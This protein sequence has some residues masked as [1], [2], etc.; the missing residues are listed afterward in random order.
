MQLLFICNIEVVVLAFSHNKIVGIVILISPLHERDLVVVASIWA[1]VTLP[2]PS[3]DFWNETCYLTWLYFY[4]V[5][6]PFKSNST[7]LSGI[8]C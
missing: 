4:I 3:H 2:L 6:D 8:P 5:I 7:N 1:S